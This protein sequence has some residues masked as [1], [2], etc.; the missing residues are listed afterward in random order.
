MSGAL[1]GAALL[2]VGAVC[3]MA[4]LKR[5]NLYDAFIEGARDGM[6]TVLGIFPA[7]LAIL[8]AVGALRASGALDWLCT[9]IA[10]LTERLGIPSE[11]VP[12]VLLRPVSGGGSLGLLADTLKS[13]GADSEVGR[14]ASVVMGATETSLYCVCVYFSKTR[15]RKTASALMCALVGDMCAVV[16]A[17]LCMKLWG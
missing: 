16:G 11:A 12:L 9:A 15:V 14:F 5:V 8:S 6:G 2:A 17:V 1:E 7:L 3:L 4:L 10:P 13:F